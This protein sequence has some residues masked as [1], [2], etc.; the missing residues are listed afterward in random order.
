MVD[1]LV[2]RTFGWPQKHP[3]NQTPATSRNNFFCPQTFCVSFI[4]LPH[5]QNATFM[6]ISGEGI[7]RLSHGPHDFEKHLRN[8]AYP[9]ALSH[10]TVQKMTFNGSLTFCF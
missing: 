5:S 3:L 7:T 4:R 8:F 1:H 10:F 9:R 6:N 2:G